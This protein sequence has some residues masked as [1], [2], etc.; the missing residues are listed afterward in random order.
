MKYVR[1]TFLWGAILF[2]LN[3]GASAVASFGLSAEP[4]LGDSMI[5]P[6][7]R[8]YRGGAYASLT[9]S[10]LSHVFT[11]KLL[12]VSPTG[13]LSKRL[14]RHLYRLCLENRLDPA[15]VLSVIQVESSFRTDA[16]SSAGAIGLMQLMPDTA[17]KYGPRHVSSKALADPFLNLEIGVRYLRTLRD[18]YAGLGAY[19]PLAAYNLGPHRL[20]ELMAKPGFR[21]EKTLRYYEEIM[22][23]VGDWR[24]YG[25][26]ALGEGRAM[27]ARRSGLK[28]KADA[29]LELS[30]A[31]ERVDAA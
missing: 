8:F 19:Y 14:A 25:A 27:P 22:R 5:Y 16:V 6:T 24:R 9:E 18:R 2:G 11:D 7:F 15:F 30:D 29:K 3:L 26:Q 13:E 28:P 17:R 31:F 4:L 1:L 21:P 20:E 23:G 10:T 12:G